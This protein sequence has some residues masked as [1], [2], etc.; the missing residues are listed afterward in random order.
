MF[1]AYSASITGVLK[2]LQIGTDATSSALLPDRR[3]LVVRAVA[4]KHEDLR[5]QW[6]ELGCLGRY[7]TAAERAKYTACRE[8]IDTALSLKGPGL[9]E[10]TVLCFSKEICEVRK[11]VPRTDDADAVI[12]CNGSK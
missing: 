6:T 10:D 12:Y 11:R 4:W 3:F 8:F 2:T 7:A 5:R 1:A 9:A